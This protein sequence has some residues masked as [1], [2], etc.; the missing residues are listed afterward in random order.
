[1]DGLS[2][3]TAEPGIQFVGGRGDGATFVMQRHAFRSPPANDGRGLSQK[4][5]DL[6]PALEITLISRIPGRGAF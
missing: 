1:M 4:S 3:F 5:G 6:S 2:G